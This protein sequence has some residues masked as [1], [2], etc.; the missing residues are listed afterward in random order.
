M[1]DENSYRMKIE[2]VEE[3]SPTLK[4]F[5]LSFCDTEKRFQFQMGQCTKLSKPNKGASYFAIASAPEEM[6]R[7]EFLVRDQK[8]GFAHELFC[9]EAGDEVE[10]SGPIGKGFPLEKL[11]GKFV[12]FLACGSGI[13][14]IAGC[15][16]SMIREPGRFKKIQLFYGVRT[17]DDFAYESEFPEWAKHAEIF[18]VVSQPHS[19][20]WHGLYGHVQDHLKE[21]IPPPGPE[22][23]IC[24]A[25]MEGMIK[26]VTPILQG[27]GIPSENILLNY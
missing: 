24:L 8:K 2:S 4:N 9:S 1:T 26:E 25:G 23:V 3:H 10:S 19:T 14:P 17:P 12:V 18:Q 13:S 22:S 15:I 16:R 27:M 20:G 7:V 11:E 21:H 5:S 6:G